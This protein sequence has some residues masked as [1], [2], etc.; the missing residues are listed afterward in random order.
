VVRYR[1]RSLSTPL[2]LPPFAF[3][4]GDS[5]LDGI[6]DLFDT[7]DDFAL[8]RLLL[9]QQSTFSYRPP[10]YVNFG[11]DPEEERLRLALLLLVTAMQQ[12]QTQSAIP[13]V[14]PCPPPLPTPPATSTTMLSP[15]PIVS[16][17]IV[18][19]PAVNQDRELLREVVLA[20][21]ARVNVDVPESSASDIL[22]K[23]LN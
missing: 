19:A 7:Q 5:D 23:G 17:P 10:S 11:A 3:S 13:Y 2:L 14:D 22:N 15:A 18:S 6:P 21:I 16:T 8:L 1:I 4:G 9:A 12:S 20:L